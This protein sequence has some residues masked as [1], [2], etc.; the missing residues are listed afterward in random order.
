MTAKAQERKCKIHSAECTTDTLT[1]RGGL[2]LFVRY[3]YGIQL[4]SHLERLFGGIRKNN[5]GQAVTEIFKQILC[6]L[7]DGTSLHLSHFDSLKKDPG[8]AATIETEA[9]AML[10]S[11]SVKRFF[12]AFSWFRIWLF[13]RILQQLFLRRLRLAK[14]EIIEIGI[15]TMVMDN[16]EASVRHGVQPTYKNV[17]GFQPLQMTWGRFLIDAVFRGGK[18]HSNHGDTVGKM[19]CHVVG[20]IR[21]HYS[22]DVPI[23]IRMDSGFFDQKL[24][25]IFEKLSIG[26]VCTGK[27][28]KDIHAVAKATENIHWKRYQKDRHVWAYFEFGDRR[29]NWS[30][31]RRALYCQPMDKNGQLLLAFVRPAN[32]IYTNIGMGCP[33]DVQLEKA[34]FSNLL[35]ASSILEM[36]HGRGSDELVHRAL[37]DFVT[38]ALPFKRFAPNAAFYYTVLLAFFL[39]ECF[40]EDVCSEVVPIESYPTT[41]RRKIID[42]AAKIVRTSGKIILKLTQSAWELLNFNKL[43]TNSG[44]PPVFTWV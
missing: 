29:G 6:F 10:S 2:Q 26:Y 40:K 37:K 16:S 31:F 35:E 20:L 34:G 14:P 30:K 4:F 44:T 33:I 24:F 12:K 8:Y 22:E 42:I 13:R 18:K 38:E 5:K 3:V 39:F 21:R 11:H 23:I 28:Y 17:M 25:K 7:V 27:L 15:D 32:V 9:G 1:S 43:W 19:V 36:S 41:L